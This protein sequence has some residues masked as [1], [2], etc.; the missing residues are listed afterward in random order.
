VEVFL[1]IAG[2]QVLGSTL[3]DAKGKYS[4]TGLASGTYKVL[5]GTTAAPL[6]H[7]ALTT[8][9]ANNIGGATLSN[10]ASSVTQQLSMTTGSVSHVDFMFNSTVNYDYGDLPLRYGMTTLAQ[11]GARHIIPAGGSTVYLGSPPDAESNGMPTAT[12]SGDDSSGSSD[13]DGV[14]AVAPGTWT[15]GAAASNKGGKIQINVTG[16]GWLVGWIDWNLDGSFLNAGEM[17]VNQAV[18]SGS[19]IISFDIPAGINTNGSH[20]WLSRF[21][22]F[23]TEPVY[24]LFSYSGEAY[25]GE[26]EDFLFMKP[27]GS[28][29][30]DY[31]TWASVFTESGFSDR[32]TDSDPDH[33]S[34]SNQAEYAFGLDPTLAVS[35]NPIVRGLGSDGTF[36]YTRRDPSLTGLT[37]TVWTSTDLR[38]WEKDVEAGAGQMVQTT[39]IDHVQTVWV[40]LTHFSATGKLFMRVQAE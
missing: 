40:K 32:A 7:A 24:P 17:I 10:T 20:S 16:G 25:D 4:F 27:A 23:T 39:G 15:H 13:E 9:T 8:T 38:K 22:I 12:A 28:S 35:G 37:Y 1:H 6:N 33:D 31:D 21:R 30:S 18:S 29:I 11:D 5:V 14:V 3:T 2:G 34:M 36:N 19:Q 26:V